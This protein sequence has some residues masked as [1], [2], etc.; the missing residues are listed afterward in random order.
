M[1]SRHRPEFRAYRIC[2]RTFPIL[3]GDAARYPG[4]WNSLGR[5][6]VYAAETFSGAMLEILVHANIGRPPRDL[7]F[8]TIV[9]PSEVA[10]EEFSGAEADVADA[11][12]SRR[13]GDVWCEEQRTA[14]LLVPSVVT[15]IERNLVINPSHPDFGRITASKPERVIWDPRLFQQ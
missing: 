14:V 13:F 8:A 10:I 15:R 4:R 9:I 5:P 3:S 1:A 11:D 7:H 12:R 6:V 2:K